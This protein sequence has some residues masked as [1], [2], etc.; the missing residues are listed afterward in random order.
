MLG[1]VALSPRHVGDYAEVA[2]ADRIAELRRLAGGLGEARIL[3][4]SLATFGSWLTDLLS[5]SI[6]LLQDLGVQADWRL[7]RPD[8]ES[9]E[10]V[11]DL[12]RALGGEADAWTPAA[13]L[14]WQRFVAAPPELPEGPYAAVIVHDPQ[15]LGL[16]PERAERSNGRRVYWIW[17]CHLDLSSATPD[18]WDDLRPYAERYDAVIFEDR[19]FAPPGWVGP[20]TIVP[21]GIDPLGPRNVPLDDATAAM[22]LGELGIDARKPMIAQISP[23]EVG[24]DALGLVEVFETL[25]PRHPELQL[26]I[27][28]TA[29][30]DDEQTRAYF[31]AVAERARVLP[32]CVV[33]PLGSEIG[34]AEINAF[35]QA[36]TL[37]V[38][39]SLRKG[40]ALWLSEAMW[41]RRPVVAGRTSGTTA[42]I[43]D[44][45]T[46]YLVPDTASCVARV[47]ELL[48]DAALRERLGGAART[49][50]TRSFLITRYLAD[51]LTLL[52]RVMGR[53][54]TV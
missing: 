51:V 33:L 38:Q 43:V 8:H 4:L 45:T 26:A 12:Y 47:G 17:D 44:G 53:L 39:K 23:F 25:L 42:Q 2:G 50:V 21:P 10:A 36:A 29:L 27:V 37:I 54:S 22:L 28:P 52:A 16:V 1:T 18:A 19:S 41:K 14:A 35:Q 5:S 15:L 24:S 31:A 30:R 40:F 49:H 48:A 11:R 9:D 7:V 6:P 13:R 34:H 46:G 3:N 32:G 20:G